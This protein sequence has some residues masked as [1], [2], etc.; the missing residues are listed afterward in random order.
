MAWPR[1]WPRSRKPGFEYPPAFRRRHEPAR[2]AS[3]CV[4]S[5]DRIDPPRSLAQ[6]ASLEAPLCSGYDDQAIRPR[7]AARWRFLFCHGHQRLRLMDAAALPAVAGFR[8]DRAMR[9]RLAKGLAGFHWHPLPRQGGPRG[10]RTVL[11]GVPAP[12]NPGRWHDLENWKPGFLKD[13]AQRKA[14]AYSP[15]RTCQ[16]RTTRCAVEAESCP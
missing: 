5:A 8:M 13:H 10:A 6:A 9:R 14:R 4:V 7:F 3:G 16:K 2:V 11:P 1:H 12:L 15:C